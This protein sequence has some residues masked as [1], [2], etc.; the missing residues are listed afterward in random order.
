MKHVSKCLKVIM[1]FDPVIPIPRIYTEPIVRN[2]KI[3]MSY[4]EVAL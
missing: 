1:L 4:V 3:I 2:N